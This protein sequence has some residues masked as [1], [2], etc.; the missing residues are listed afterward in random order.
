MKTGMNRNKVRMHSMYHHG[1]RAA[2]RI[3]RKFKLKWK[4]Q[5]IGFKSDE[6]NPTERLPG[7][8][9]LAYAQSEI[10]FRLMLNL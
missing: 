5:L 6:R 3:T 10:Q 1:T 7:L 9:T 8:S 4:A 2:F